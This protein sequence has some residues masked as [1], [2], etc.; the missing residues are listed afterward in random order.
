DILVNRSGLLPARPDFSENFKSDKQG[1]ARELEQMI[2]LN[3]PIT[4]AEYMLYALQHPTLGYYM[5]KES[6]IGQR[7]DFVTAPEI[8]QVFGELIGVWCVATW[9]A[10]GSPSSFNM[11]ELGP[12]KGTLMTDV[13]RAASSFP[14]FRKAL[15]LHLVE[16]SDDLRALQVK[17][18]NAKYPDGADTDSTPSS[19]PLP[20]IMDG[21]ITGMLLP[22]GGEVFWHTK[23]DQQVPKGPSLFIAQEF[24]DALPIHKF[25]YTAKG[26]REILV[27]MNVK[28]TETGAQGHGVVDAGTEVKDTRTG[29]GEVTGDGAGN[30]VEDFR[31][32]VSAEETAA[33]KTFLKS[34]EDAASTSSKPAG[35]RGEK[36]GD[37]LEVSPESMLIAAEVAKRVAEHG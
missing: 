31:F 18:L 37:R 21:G 34:K 13:L 23:M 11:I 3:G 17:A 15:T 5:R 7:G 32:V 4:V 9:N 14:A 20:S 16:T 19:S 35:D 12:G 2:N 28:V 10:M 33:V 36:V 29:G 25:Q 6:K 8:S 30:S 22:D 26:W 27:D 24:L 1:L